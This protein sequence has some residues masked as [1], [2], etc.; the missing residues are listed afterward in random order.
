MGWTN[1]VPIFH[2]NITSILQLEIPHNVLSFIDNVGTKESKN[3]NIVNGK[4]AKHPANP[5]ICL[6]LWEFFELLN[7]ILQQMKY[8][9]GTFSVDSNQARWSTA[10]YSVFWSEHI[11]VCKQMGCSPYYATTGTHPLLPADIVE[12]TYLQPLPNFLLSTT[13]LIVH[14]AIDL[15]CQQEDLDHLHSN[16]FSTCHL[17]AICFK[18]G[19]AATI[20]NY[21]FQASDFVLMR[22]TRIKVIHNKKMKPC[23]LGPLVVISCNCGSAYILCKLDGSVLHFPIAT[24]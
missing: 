12:V 6:A 14:Q 11:T 24:F 13:N 22:N 1:S 19:H 8:C 10:T 7:R 3:W 9:G 21:N 17:A 18:A 20:C 16:L 23:Y 15:Q 4:P 2:D 5:N